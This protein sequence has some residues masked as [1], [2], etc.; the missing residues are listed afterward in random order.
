M[1]WHTLA[2]RVEQRN[3]SISRRLLYSLE[4]VGQI[5]GLRDPESKTLLAITDRM[6]FVTQRHHHE[7][8][9]G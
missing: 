2:L 6:A 3:F 8:L 9:L 1:L 7:G 5:D 4:S